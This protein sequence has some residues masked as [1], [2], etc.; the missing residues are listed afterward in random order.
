[1]TTQ[2]E[3]PRVEAALDD[4]R[5]WSDALPT[6]DVDAGAARH[7]E[8]VREGA[9]AGALARASSRGWWIAGA[10]A[11]IVFGLLGAWPREKAAAAIA[12]SDPQEVAPVRAA[13]DD[14]VVEPARTTAA[15]EAAPPQP[16]IE[17]SPAV[18]RDRS[19]K[20]K[21]RVVRSV[22]PVDAAQPQPQPQPD[23]L[24]RELAIVRQMRRALNDSPSRVLSLA[25]EADREIGRGVFT[26]ERA[27]LRVF[28]LAR[29]DDARANE[30]AAAFLREFSGGP[31][32]GRIARLREAPGR[33][34]Q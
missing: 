9:G 21:P 22:E 24:E 32:A 8:I 4:L 33:D 17:A 18:S 27:A 31:F 11:A 13:E 2:S 15:V 29:L 25:D 34:A 5:A 12:E 26:E 14:R 23:T 30:A 16:S 3:D 20:R 1:M 19:A 6:Y 10:S 7:V 28:A